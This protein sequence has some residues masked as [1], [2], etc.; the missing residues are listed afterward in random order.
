MATE[1][2][3]HAVRPLRTLDPAAPLDDLGW[4]DAV[5]GDA[6]VV[7]IGESAHYNR[8]SALLRHRLLRYLVERHGTGAG[9]VSTNLALGKATSESSHTQVL[10]SSNVTDGNQDSYWE[11]TNGVFPQFV[12]VDLGSAQSADRVVLQLPAPWGARAQTLSVQGSTHGATF[13]TVKASATYTFDPA[14]DNTVTV[15]FPATTQWFFRVNIT[16]NNGWPAGQV[17]LFQVWNNQGQAAVLQWAGDRRHT[18]P[19]SW[20]SRAICVRLPRSSLVRM[21]VTFVFTV[22]TLMCS[23]SAISAFVAPRPIAMATSCS[24][25]LS[26]A[27]AE[28]AVA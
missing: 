16:A 23:V 25:A 13:S 15:T 19:A 6:R 24:R 2:S 17:S 10:A 11:S 4:L 20:V 7:A 18:S 8:E 5:I 21:R 9:A 12:Q 26:P 3:D 27:S 1:L 14:T 22:A 28:R